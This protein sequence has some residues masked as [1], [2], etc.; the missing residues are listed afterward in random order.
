MSHADGSPLVETVRVSGLDR[1]LRQSLGPVAQADRAARLG[2]VVLN[3]V[4]SIALGGDCLADVA[5]LRA[6]PAVFGPVWALA[7]GSI[8]TMSPGDVG[9]GDACA[10]PH[11]GLALI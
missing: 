2:Q 11:E 10:G 6:A 9:G 4:L 1:R 7:P 8:L 3:V 5:V